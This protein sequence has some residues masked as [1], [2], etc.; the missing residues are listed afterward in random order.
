MLN[1]IKVF[2]Q[3]LKY[4]KLLHKGCEAVLRQTDELTA[5]QMAEIERPVNEFRLNFCIVQFI[6]SRGSIYDYMH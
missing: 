3:Y 5:S 2:T 4:V 6:V 1:N